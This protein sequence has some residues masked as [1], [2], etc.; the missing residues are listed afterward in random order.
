MS[1]S[2][3]PIMCSAASVA[4]NEPYGASLSFRVHPA[5]EGL[6]RACGHLFEVERRCDFALGKAWFRNL[7]INGLPSLAE[8]RYGVLSDGDRT[9]GIIPLRDPGADELGGLANCYTCLYRPLIA[10][11][12]QGI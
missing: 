8:A 2:A 6:P 4:P 10:S 11:E 12:C 3:A 1:G 5:L 9:I 7:A